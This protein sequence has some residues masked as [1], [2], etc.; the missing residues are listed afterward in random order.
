MEELKISNV[1]SADTSPP[2]PA[3][4]E[5]TTEQEDGHSFQRVLKYANSVTIQAIL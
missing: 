2:D 3:I 4:S 5:Q 1:A